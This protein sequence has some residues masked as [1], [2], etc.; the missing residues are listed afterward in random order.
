MMVGRTSPTATANE[1]YTGVTDKTLSTRVAALAVARGQTLADSYHG[2]QFANLYTDAGTVNRL[3]AVYTVVGNPASDLP[4]YLIDLT[5][6]FNFTLKNYA[7][8]FRR[9]I[10]CAMEKGL[11]VCSVIIDNLPAQKSGL[12]DALRQAI[13][14]CSCRQISCYCHCLSLV[15]TNTLSGCPLLRGIISQVEK[16]QDFLR[17]KIGVDFLGARCPLIP[18]TRWLYV[19][20]ILDFIAANAAKIQDLGRTLT[21]PDRR[22]DDSEDGDDADGSL[23]GNALMHEMANGVPLLFEECRAILRPIRYLCD[24]FE[25]RT[26]ALWQVIPLA[27]K[28]IESYRQRYEARFWKHGDS[29]TI[30]KQILMK[31][32][33]RIGS[34]SPA[35]VMLAFLLSPAGRKAARNREY[36]FTIKTNEYGPEPLRPEVQLDVPPDDFSLIHQRERPAG[37]EEEMLE[38]EEWQNVEEYPAV[39][40][41]LAGVPTAGVPTAGKEDEEEEEEEEEEE[42]FEEITPGYLDILAELV[43]SDIPTILDYKPWHHMHERTLRELRET[44]AL[45]GLDVEFIEECF[46]K[47]LWEDTRKLPFAKFLAGDPDEMWRQAHK[48][49]GWSTFSNFALRFITIGTS[50]AEVERLISVQRDIAALKSVRVTPKMAM[51]RLQMRLSRQRSEL[52]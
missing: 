52:A 42:D 25:R 43:D 28:V 51:A 31:F 1:L 19:T 3:H 34:N 49:A 18:K 12:K 26:S 48:C 22:R 41:P 13:P 32:R 7:S 10:L 40:V 50:E 30:L 2:V 8:Y 11:V 16:W 27:K 14:T 39:G 46:D 35:T 45:A 5:E 47:W 6:N 24:V 44:A 29:Y 17:G 36:G 9:V 38:S 33:A 20:G 23:S 37:E 4:P 15:F 21:T